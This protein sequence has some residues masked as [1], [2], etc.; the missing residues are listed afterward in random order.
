MDIALILAKKYPSLQWS[1]NANDY[2]QIEVDNG[3]KPSLSKLET[4]WVEVQAELMQKKFTD[5]VQSM[6]DATAK[7]K[8]YD[9]IV[10]ACSYASVANAFQAEGI[11]FLEWRSA[12]WAK[13]YQIMAE[14]QAG[15]RTVPTEKELLVELPALALPS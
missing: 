1:I 2:S 4:A 14:V 8:G 7:T 15:T 6:L 13:C 10:S 3:E 11:A 9:N 12:V 5:A